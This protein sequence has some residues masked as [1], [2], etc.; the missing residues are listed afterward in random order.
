[1]MA[2]FR[3]EIS[4]L[5]LRSLYWSCTALIG[6]SMSGCCVP[7]QLFHCC[8]RI[9]QGDRTQWVIVAGSRLLGMLVCKLVAEYTTVSW[10][11]LNVNICWCLLD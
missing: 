5:F 6:F 8:D 4:A 2:S 10:H 3:L 11:P 7:A 9:G 1:M